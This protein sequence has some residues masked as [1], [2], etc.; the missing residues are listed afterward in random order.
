[1]DNLIFNYIQN[2]DSD[3]M[4]KIILWVR[5]TKHSW[6]IH[7]LLSKGIKIDYN[8]FYHD[9]T[10]HD[11]INV[12]KI[13]FQKDTKNINR[14]VK[15]MNNYNIDFITKID[16]EPTIYNIFGCPKSTDLD[17]VIVVDK[18]VIINTKKYNIKISKIVEKLTRLYP[19]KE[20]DIN[21]ISLNNRGNIS[22]ASKGSYETQNMC[23]YT[24]K[25]HKQICP[26]IFSNPI[27]IS[28]SD[29]SVRNIVQFI[30][31]K[32]NSIKIIG[33]ER[34][35]ELRPERKNAEV[36]SNLRIEYAFNILS[37]GLNKCFR[38]NIK[39]YR[40]NFK[41]MC[42]IIPE[43]NVN[44]IS[45]MKSL[46]MK[47]IQ[48]HQRRLN[49]L[50]SYTKDELTEIS[51]RWFTYKEGIR[52]F[53]MRGNNGNINDAMNSIPEIIKQVRYLIDTE[54]KINWN[55]SKLDTSNNPTNINNKI[56]N[57]FL[58][59]PIICTP[60]FI[61]VF[62]DIYGKQEYMN[63]LD[64]Q[65]LQLNKL[66]KNSS[67]DFN[68]L[69]KWLQKNV[70][71]CHQRSEEWQEWLIF[72]TCG[73]NTGV[74]K[75]QIGDNIVI[76]RYNLIRGCIMEEFAQQYIFNN[77]IDIL[78]NYNLN[79][80]KPVNIGLIVKE[81]NVKGSLGA[82]PDL[83]FIN[84]DEENIIIVEIKTMKTEFNENADYRRAV[85]LATKQ[86]SSI[87]KISD[88]CIGGLIVIL[89]YE[90]KQWLFYHHYFDF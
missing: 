11:I 21:Y 76:E 52:Y 59:S 39:I 71:N 74:K 12:L 72:Y 62:E 9:I 64:E 22:M 88:H 70:I 79:N 86:C 35:N 87:K 5:N 10:K 49:I 4:A 24:Y 32:P 82:A 40:N 45:I 68:I 77:Y 51:S 31:L 29:K 41:F 78:C 61:Q 48:T 85:D 73:M 19:E 26:P 84:E 37:E 43:L 7:N 28:E 36:E 14:F 3:D 44:M 34:Y 90:E 81:K 53:L 16:I 63:N 58:E 55:I 60:K 69:P 75:L 46:I 56:V 47:I 66:F 1:M 25:Y 27:E 67:T 15:T 50:V 54:N 20:I 30:T 38:W 42:K 6:V 18:D 80:Y 83:L 65:R 8:N 13:Y 17:V 23:Y 33:K 2:A 57:E 89:W